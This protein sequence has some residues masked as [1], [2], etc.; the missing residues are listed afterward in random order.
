MMNTF[1]RGDPEVERVIAEVNALNAAIAADS[2]ALAGEARNM[3]REVEAKWPETRTFSGFVIRAAMSRIT[4][5]TPPTGEPDRTTGDEAEWAV[6]AFE[7]V[8]LAW[9]AWSRG[10]NSRAQFWIT[11]WGRESATQTQLSEAG[12]IQAFTVALWANAIEALIENRTEDSQRFF[13]RVH[14]VGS[15]YGTES[16]PTI[17]WTMAASFFTQEG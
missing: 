8:G 17:L 5:S 12:A 10:E 15:S 2:P 13:R 1:G 3:V 16:H 9:L 6:R 14:D 4:G 11:Q 7:L